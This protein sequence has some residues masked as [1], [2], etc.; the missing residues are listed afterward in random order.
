M[1]CRV[2]VEV[3]VVAAVATVEVVA[4]VNCVLKDTC[5]ST[6]RSSKPTTGNN[7]SKLNFSPLILALL[8]QLAY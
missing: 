6:D 2:V 8:R 4:V 1:Q 7:M 3:S 5:L